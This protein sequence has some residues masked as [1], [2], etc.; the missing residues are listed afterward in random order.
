MPRDL[1]IAAHLALE[2]HSSGGPRFIFACAPESLATMALVALGIAVLSRAIAAG[3]P[4]R[5]RVADGVVIVALAIVSTVV[6]VDQK[7]YAVTGLHVYDPTVREVLLSRGGNH[8]I[9]LGAGTFLSLAAFLLALIVAGA[10]VIE[11][12][13]R[14]AN[15]LGDS[16]RAAAYATGAVVLAL[17]ALVASVA[18]AK[19]SLCRDDFRVT[20]TVRGSDFVPKWGPVH[21][22]LPAAIAAQGRPLPHPKNILFV[23]V[24]SLRSDTF[25][26]ELTPNLWARRGECIVPTHHYSG[27]HRTDLGTFTAL[28][29]VNSYNYVPFREQTVSS[30]PLQL[31]KKNGYAVSGASASQLSG[32]V[33]AGFMLGTFDAF[34]EHLE[35][36]SYLDD[37]AVLDDALAFDKTRDPKAPFFLFLF[38]HATHHNYYYPPEFARYAPAMPQDYDHFMGD[39]RLEAFHAEIRNRYKN[40]VLYADS[41]LGELFHHFDPELESGELAIVVTGD[42]GEEFWEHGLLGHSVPRFHNERVEVPL[43]LCL[44]G[45]HGSTPPLSGH[46]DIWP[47]LLDVLGFDAPPSS[48]SD[49]VSLARPEDPG[50]SIF[51]GGANFPRRDSQGCIVEGAEKTWLSLCPGRSFCLEPTQVTNLDDVLLK[52]DPGRAIARVQDLREHFEHFSPLDPAN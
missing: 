50:R 16:K 8:E 40:S 12:G 20:P 10:A 11:V 30:F 4:R 42:H 9:A 5:S 7:A 39:D 23:L 44:P 49:G 48:F 52:P 28:Y 43:L 17:S 37:R 2:V 29:G 33:G 35:T 21:Y 46:A 32:W 47:T 18:G 27:G 36:G 25:G 3:S 31:L 45:K 14:V 6:I 26:P 13:R 41:L 22:P 51:I 34:H 15:R 24:E 38:F 19:P 1:V